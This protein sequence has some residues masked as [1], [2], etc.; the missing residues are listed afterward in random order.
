MSAR[1]PGLHHLRFVHPEP[2]RGQLLS[3]PSLLH[4]ASFGVRGL[5]SGKVTGSY[6][7]LQIFGRQSLACLSGVAECSEMPHGASVESLRVV[8]RRAL[9]GTRCGVPVIPM[10]VVGMRS[11]LQ[12]W[13]C[14]PVPRSLSG[15]E[16][17]RGAYI[18]N[19][20]ALWTCRLSWLPILWRRRTGTPAEGDFFYTR[21]T[22]S[23]T[24]TCF[25][26]PILKVPLLTAH[27]RHPCCQY[28]DGR[29]HGALPRSHS[30]GEPAHLDASSAVGVPGHAAGGY[31][32][33]ISPI[34]IPLTSRLRGVPK[35]PG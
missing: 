2:I 17:A 16:L 12:S 14:G 30:S 31:L 25:C 29:Q 19:A 9:W 22:P 8:W 34:V 20:F 28:D 27:A 33:R 3:P 11:W 21:I 5:L 6:K 13:S 1:T 24:E 4:L 32:L 10:I 23:A 7:R 35:R 18:S 26:H 15:G